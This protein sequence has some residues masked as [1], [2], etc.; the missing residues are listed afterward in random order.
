MDRLS[1]IKC[2]LSTVVRCPL[3]QVRLYLVAVAR[4]A[5]Q[6]LTVWGNTLYHR[7]EAA[8]HIMLDMNYG[9]AYISNKLSFIGH[10]QL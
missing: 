8:L 10:N 2:P 3:R 7:L 5:C 4:V 6:T 1:E 9:Y